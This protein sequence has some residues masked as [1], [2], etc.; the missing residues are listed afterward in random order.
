M[1]ENLKFAENGFFNVKYLRLVFRP[2]YTKHVPGEGVPTSKDPNIRGDLV[3]NFDIAFP[4]K[5]SS[6]QKRLLKDALLP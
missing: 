4:N 5:L 6:E 3:I 2:G 1:P